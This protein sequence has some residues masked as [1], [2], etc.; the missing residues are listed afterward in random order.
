MVPSSGLTCRSIR[1]RSIATVPA[2]FGRRALVST[3]PAWM[4][5]K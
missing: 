1:V 4:S 2:F 5:A 3:R